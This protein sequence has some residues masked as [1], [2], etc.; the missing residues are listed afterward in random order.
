MQPKELETSFA[1]IESHAHKHTCIVD[2]PRKNDK[3]QQA[4]SLMNP[5]IPQT[6]AAHS[7]VPNPSQKSNDSNCLSV[8]QS[9]SYEY[10][11]YFPFLRYTLPKKIT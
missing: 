8:Q 3:K 6:H 1:Q 2:T 10:I 7:L 5:K 4:S 11:A 9:Q